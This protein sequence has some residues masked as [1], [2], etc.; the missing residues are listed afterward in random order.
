M[1]RPHALE[2]LVTGQ[3]ISGLIA[4]VTLIDRSQKWLS[5]RI[6]PHVID[7]EV[8]GV[9][10]AFDDVTAVVKAQRIVQIMACLLYTSRCV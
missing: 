8:L 7:G 3:S 4:G 1:N 9:M 6:W 10:S 2:T 5:A